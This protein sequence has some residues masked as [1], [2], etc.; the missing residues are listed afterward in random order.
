MSYWK[1]EHF[2]ALQKEWYRR[3]AD[4]G[5]DD[6]ESVIEGEYELKDLRPYRS[7][8]GELR[9]IRDIPYYDKLT[10]LV[11]AHNFSDE[12]HKI[13]LTLCSQGKRIKFICLEL[14][15]MGT[16]RTREAIRFIIRKYEM[17]WGIKQYSKKQLNKW[18]L[19]KYNKK[20]TA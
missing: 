4:S 14:K 5:F 3:A 11:N 13:V 17:L 10:D 6:H 12:V 9:K 1:S 15:K 19:R 16:P 20:Q 7:H 8:E 18:G 2:K